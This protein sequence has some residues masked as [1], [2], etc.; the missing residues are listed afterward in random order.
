MAGP[1]RKEHHVNTRAIAA[2]VAAAAA[3]AATTIIPAT[4]EAA[5]PT[6]RLASTYLAIVR[7]TNIAAA[8]FAAESRGMTYAQFATDGPTYAAPVIAALE[9]ADYELARTH[10]PRQTAAD[11]KQLIRS[12]GAEIGDLY[13]LGNLNPL[14]PEG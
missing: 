14:S 10:W 3:T 13:A 6:W 9:R 8:R 1:E 12:I 4:S 7:P 11:V 2:T 5:T